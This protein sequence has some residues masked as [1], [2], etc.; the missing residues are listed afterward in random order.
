MPFNP[1]I[2]A[3]DIRAGLKNSSH[4]LNPD[5]SKNTLCLS[6]MVGMGKDMGVHFIS[7]PPNK[8]GRTSPP[9]R[10]Q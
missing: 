3:A 2:K 7:L 9:L 4:F 10:R 6:D 5:V 8:S 1:L